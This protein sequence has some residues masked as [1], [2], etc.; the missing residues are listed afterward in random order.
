MA[1]HFEHEVRGPSIPP[2]VALEAAGERRRTRNWDFV[3]ADLQRSVI[4]AIFPGEP[5]SA[6]TNSSAFPVRIQHRPSHAVRV[7][8]DD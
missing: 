8:Y 5:W 6:S 7:A 3:E 2:A 1:G 4:D